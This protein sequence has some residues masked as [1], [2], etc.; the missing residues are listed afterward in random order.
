M[1]SIWAMETLIRRRKP[2]AGDLK[3]EVAVVGAGMAGI[4]IAYRL[5][6]AGRQ[7][8][9][10]EAGRIGG[11]QTRNTTAKITSQHGMFCQKLI[12]NL[13]R[14]RARQYAAANEAAIRAYRELI[15]SRGIDCDLEAKC[16][17]L[18]G[19]DREALQREAEAAA[20]LGLPAVYLEQVPLPV[21]GAG[22]VRFAGQA[23]FAPLR[24]LAAL[25]EKL[26]VYEQTR[27][28]RAEG[29]TLVTDRG[30]VQAEQIVF[31]CHYPF[32][33]FPG[34][35]FARM[36]QERSYVL[37]LENVPKLDGMFIGASSD[38]CSLRTYGDLL[39]MG[40][41]SHRTGEDRQGGRYAALRQRAK[42]WFPGCREVACWSAQDC[43]TA[44][45]V[46]YIGRYAASRPDWFVATGFH[47]WGMTSSMAAAMV[48]EDLMCGRESPYAAAFDPGRVTLGLLP[49]V[50]EESVQ[51]A[52]G[53]AKTFFQ[54]PKERTILPGHG[55]ETAVRGEKADVYR[56]DDGKALAV[57]LRCPHLGCQLTWNPDENSWD[58]P[59]HGSRFDKEG[60]LLSGPAQKDLRK[61]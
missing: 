40:G 46:P 19:V 54:P 56:E 28:L 33:N 20:S 43:I 21:P 9:V 61:R 24:F 55:G 17:Y 48:L 26:T 36:H 35:Y 57:S 6:K 27:V 50:A 52:R 8:V 60:H 42:E 45:G 12:Q 32:I 30:Q 37:A 1:A 15:D 51:A 4:L 44:D 47:K 16:A 13:G 58:C 41:E 5:Q 49:G 34:L 23:Q 29:Q 11:G 3:T 2:L 10:L 18:Y 53:L 14:E 31:A 7:V 25:A 38:A 59:C 22:A 39:L